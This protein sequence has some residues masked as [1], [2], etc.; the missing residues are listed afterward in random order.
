MNGRPLINQVRKYLRDISDLSNQGSFWDDREIILALNAAQ[1]VILKSLIN[2]KQYQALNRLVS[3]RLYNP[4]GT[5]VWRTLPSDY[6]HYMSAQTS[7]L[8]AVRI[9]NSG[10]VVTVYEADLPFFST[11]GLIPDPM[12]YKYTLHKTDAESLKTAKIYLGGESSS[13]LYSYHQAVFIV[14]NQICAQGDT[15]FQD[16][17]PDI[18]HPPFILYYYKRPSKIW[19]REY[20]HPD[21]IN[22]PITDAD[23][24]IFSFS[25]T[26][27]DTIC[28]H[29]SVMLSFKETQTQRDIKM[30]GAVAAKLGSPL[31]KSS[32]Y[33]RDQDI[34]IMQRGTQNAKSPE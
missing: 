7:S 2:N 14:G 8:D 11:V 18:K 23:I 28:Q 17:I 21:V 1:D 32:L 3:A 12:Y 27:Y 19:L 13:F 5:D 10:I 33:L 4:N 29:A 34:T 20:G 31:A 16:Q 22:Q 15:I 30:A 25:Q 9:E 26:E 6:I 24:D